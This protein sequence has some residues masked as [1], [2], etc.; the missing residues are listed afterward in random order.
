MVCEHSDPSALASSPYST[1]PTT[2]TANSS[3]NPTSTCPKYF[4]DIRII[5]LFTFEYVAMLRLGSAYVEPLL[6]YKAL[7]LL[8]KLFMVL[9]VFTKGG[10]FGRFSV[11]RGNLTKKFKRAGLSTLRPI[12]VI[13]GDHYNPFRRST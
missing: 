8:I 10:L 9:L 6:K 5:S 12:D 7:K 11:A 2:S 4:L 1:L 3:L 13:E